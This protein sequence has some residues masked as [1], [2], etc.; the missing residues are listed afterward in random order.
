MTEPESRPTA[1]GAKRAPRV[2][3]SYAQGVDAHT[4]DVRRL[5]LLLRENDV[6]ARMDGPAAEQPQDW[7]KWMQDEI[8][9]A[10]FTLVIASARYHN[11]AEGKQEQGTGRGVAWEARLVRNLAHQ[12]PFDWDQRILGVVLPGESETKLPTFMA[13][14]STT[15]YTLPAIDRPG[16]EKLLR[17]LTG[18]PYETYSPLGPRPHLPARDHSLGPDDATPAG[19]GAP[20]LRAASDRAATYITSY[21]GIAV[22]TQGSGSVYIHQSPQPPTGPDART[23]PS[24][25]EG[26]EEPTQ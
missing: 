1:E 19:P 18:Q 14:G 26:E 3:I 21:G 23:A 20:G 16:I 17:Y 9:E 8:H 5:W 2:F 10:D 25:E 13:G 12:N 11:S 4:E 22:G 6:D 24:Q 7:P 15:T